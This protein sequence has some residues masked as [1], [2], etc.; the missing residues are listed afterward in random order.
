MATPT[1][2]RWP[3]GVTDTTDIGAYGSY[4]GLRPFRY[5]N[6]INDFD[7][8]VSGQWV[9]TGPSGSTQ[10]IGATADGGA[11]VLTIGTTGSTADQSIQWAGNSGAVATTYYWQATKDMLICAG[12]K[13][14]D[15]TND[16][17]VVGLASTD[18]TPASSLPTSFIGFTKAAATQALLANIRIAG[19][20][21]TIA[22]GNM[23]DNTYVS[24]VLFYSATTGNWQ[25]FVN[26]GLQGT[27]AAA[28]NTPTA[29]LAIT[30]GHVNASALALMSIDYLQVANQR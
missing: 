6:W 3:N 29:A 10:A 11:L 30:V 24:C 7:N 25:A 17:L 14:S 8:Y 16:G 23:A 1:V 18:T 15:S 4:A 21:T 28:S 27:A 26:D 2:T 22:C 13:T 20:S 19:V 12:F 5:H 9:V